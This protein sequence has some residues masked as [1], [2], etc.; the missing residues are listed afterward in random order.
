[1][2]QDDLALY[3][4]DVVSVA[5]FTRSRLSESGNWSNRSRQLRKTGR[6]PPYRS[7]CSLHWTVL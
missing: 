6:D 5:S 2:P 7:L 4:M 3:D 1:M